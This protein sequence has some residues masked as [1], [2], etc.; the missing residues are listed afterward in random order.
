MAAAPCQLARIYP[1]LVDD[2]VH[3][4]AALNGKR[5]DNGADRLRERILDGSRWPEPFHRIGMAELDRLGNVEL[6]GLGYLVHV[7][8]GLEL[9]GG[10]LGLLRG[11]QLSF[12]VQTRSRTLVS[13]SLNSDCFAGIRSFKTT[14]ASRFAG[15]TSTGE[16]SFFF[17]PASAPSIS[18]LTPRPGIASFAPHSAPSPAQC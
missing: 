14:T 4:V 10:F 3:D 5:A 6:H 16:T 15:N 8:A 9:V 13:T 18:G 7:L 17:M 12:L 2:L 1:L 11:Q